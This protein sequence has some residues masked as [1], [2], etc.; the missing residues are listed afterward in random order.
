MDAE[1]TWPTD[2]EMN[3]ASNKAKSKRMIKRVPEGMSV[4]QSAWIPDE[5]SDHGNVLGIF[6]C[7]NI[8]CLIFNLYLY[9]LTD[10]VN[11][12]SDEDSDDFYSIK[13][14]NSDSEMKSV[15]DDE[16][17]TMSMT[18]YTA[19]EAPIEDDKYDLQF[20]INEEE[21]IL[22]KIK[23]QNCCLKV[24]IKLCHIGFY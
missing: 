8:Q 14:E 13:D 11:S 12:E 1:Q 4:Y 2:E 21:K 9:I 6:I 3:E 10:D 20:D 24:N 22:A 15:V 17:D 18:S 7:L 19:S 5:E 23:G 16:M